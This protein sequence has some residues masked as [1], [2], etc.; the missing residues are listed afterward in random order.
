MS[1]K[2]LPSIHVHHYK[3]TA[4]CATEVMPVPD[5]VKISMSQHIGAPCKPLV[6][7]GDYVKVGQLLGDTEAFVSAPIHSSVSGTV[8][9][10]EE[11]RSANG[12][13]DTLVVIETDKQQEIYEGIEVPVANDLPEFVK[14]I[15]A[16]G[17]VGLGGASF[18]THIKFNPKN[19]DAVHTLIVN[20][21]E[22]EPFITSDHRLMLEDAEDLIAGCQLVMKFLGLSEGFIGIEDNK[23]DAI[24]H[25]DQLLAAKGITNIKTFKLQ[26]RYPKGAERV[27][28]YEV[29]GK[30]MNAGVLP[31]D[32][33]IILSNVTTIA[34]VGQYFRN[35][36]PLITKRMTVDGD[37][38]ARPT[39]VI[40]PIGTQIHDVIEFCGGYKQEPRKILM[41]GPMMGRAIFSDE[42]PIVKNNNAI[43]AFSKAQ[44]LVKEETAC[45]NCGKCHQAC[46]FKL[47]PTALAK[48]YEMRDA[49]ALSDLKVMQC[50][51]CGSCSY[52]CPARRPLAF[53]NKLGKGVVKE[54]GIK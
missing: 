22:C 11:V 31:A 32:L 34:F 3:H 26:A 27:L 46:P 25:L 29:T 8:T 2:H 1:Q 44:A 53:T 42:L 33:G 54:A 23:M 50:M 39:N 13:K 41:G 28:V 16:S 6:K 4:G 37:A 48:A 20:A 43:L 24:Q 19:I 12:G 40:A 5:V 21:A 10:I 14:A 18:P 17:L 9:G 47:I 15:R 7:K 52:I 35:G 36:M 45:I 51:E 30:T 38:V 49:Q